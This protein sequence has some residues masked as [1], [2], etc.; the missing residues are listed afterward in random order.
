MLKE[1]MYTADN[2]LKAFMRGEGTSEE[3]ISIYV[4][5]YNEVYLNYLDIQDGV[6]D[7][8]IEKYIRDS[9]NSFNSLLHFLDFDTIDV[10]ASNSLLYCIEEINSKMFMC[11]SKLICKTCS[12]DLYKKFIELVPTNVKSN[13]TIFLTYWIVTVLERSSEEYLMLLRKH[14]V[15]ALYLDVVHYNVDTKIQGDKIT[16][17]YNNKIYDLD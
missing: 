4:N 11:F 15:C 5:L 2:Y 7:I 8:L 10:R 6:V 9:V 1:A 12:S 17:T 13:K 3:L 14:A 16:L